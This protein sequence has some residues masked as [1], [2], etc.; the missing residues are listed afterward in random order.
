[1]ILFF[2]YEYA[3]RLA[4][5]TDGEHER[6]RLR[7]IEEVVSLQERRR[8]RKVRLRIEAAVVRPRAEISAGDAKIDAREAEARDERAIDRVCDRDLAELRVAAILRELFDDVRVRR[9][10]ACVPAFADQHRHSGART[11]HRS[12]KQIRAELL[13]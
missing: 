10:V 6:S 4:V 13:V 2:I 9:T 7:H 5:E 3:R 8:A 12:H 11:S 1:M